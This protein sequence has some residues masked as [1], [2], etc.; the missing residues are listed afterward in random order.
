VEQ[1]E[2]Q[3][4]DLPLDA[5]T[6]TLGGGL[7]GPGLKEKREAQLS[8][9]PLGGLTDALG[10]GLPVPGAKEKRDPQL[11]ALTGLLGGKKAAN[12]TQPADAPRDSLKE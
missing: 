11:D 3:L 5:L 1:R 7:P 6:D 8:G 2:A 10:G 9:L 4:D 12:A